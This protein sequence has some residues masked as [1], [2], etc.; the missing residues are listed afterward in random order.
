MGFLNWLQE[1]SISVNPVWKNGLQRLV[2]QISWKQVCKAVYLRKNKTM[3][4]LQIEK[5]FHIELNKRGIQSRFWSITEDQVYNWRK[6]QHP[7]LAN[8]SRIIF[9][10]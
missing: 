1:D 7:L 8:A 6:G 4:P 10:Q 2:N 5:A 3:T 9:T